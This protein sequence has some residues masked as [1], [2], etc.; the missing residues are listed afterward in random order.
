MECGIEGIRKSIARLEDEL[1]K[2]KN[3]LRELLVKENPNRRVQLLNE[4]LAK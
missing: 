4:P 3:K 2:Q 1:F